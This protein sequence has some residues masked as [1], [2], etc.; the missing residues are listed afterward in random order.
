MASFKFNGV[1]GIA[2]SFEELANLSTEAKTKII[3]A[4]AEVLRKAQSDKLVEMFQ[5]ENIAPSIKVTIKER[6][7]EPVAVVAPSGKH[8]GSTTGKRMKTDKNGKRRSSG[9]YTGSN[10]EIAYFLE[11]GTPRMPA[12]HWMETANEEATEAF[13]AAEAAAWDEHLTEIGL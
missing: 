8:P 7:G 1:D 2:A 12:R 3:T 4:G 9:S 11:Y 5:S 13:L 10:A 6:D